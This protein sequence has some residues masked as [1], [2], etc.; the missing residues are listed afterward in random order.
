MDSNI[1]ILDFFIY[2]NEMAQ[3]N[4]ISFGNTKSTVDQISKT[5]TVT[6]YLRALKN[7]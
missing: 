1:I 4:Y 5:V 3:K 6:K 7:N 2:T